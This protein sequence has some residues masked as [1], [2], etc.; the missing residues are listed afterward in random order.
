MR[1]YLHKTKLSAF[2]YCQY[3]DFYIVSYWRTYEWE[4]LENDSLTGN[5]L[6]SAPTKFLKSINSERREFF[7]HFVF[8]QILGNE[9]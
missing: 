4:R 2:Q 8:L 9:T 7:F 1:N 5:F 6:I 3:F